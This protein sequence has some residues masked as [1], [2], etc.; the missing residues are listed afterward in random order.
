MGQGAI[1][2]TDPATPEALDHE[3]EVMRDELGEII[4]ELDQR[5]HRLFRWV[6][7]LRRHKRA[8][9]IAAAC[10]TVLVLWRWVRRAKAFPSARAG[11][12]HLTR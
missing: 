4:G 1:G 3:V 10:V 9:G 7:Q 6:P 2:V 12:S 11:R 8:V 5:R